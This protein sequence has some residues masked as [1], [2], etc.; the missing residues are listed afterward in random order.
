M[1]EDN[2]LEA[3]LGG[4]GFLPQKSEDFS[5]GLDV[6]VPQSDIPRLRRVIPGISLRNRIAPPDHFATGYPSLLS[7]QA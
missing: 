2:D 5:Y 6:L 1:V 4:H 3:A 7:I